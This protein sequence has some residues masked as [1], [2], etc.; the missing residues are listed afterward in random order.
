MS[1]VG[2]V[3]RVRIVFQSQGSSGIRPTAGASPRQKRRA[4]NNST[5]KM[6]LAASADM[7]EVSHGLQLHSLWIIPTAAVS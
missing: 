7:R 6:S 4:A 1:I 3:R 2:R 5:L